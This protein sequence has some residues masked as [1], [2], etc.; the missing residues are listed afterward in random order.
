[1]NR[2]ARRSTTTCGGDGSSTSIASSLVSTS[3]AV[4][5]SSSPESTRRSAPSLSTVSKPMG[6]RRKAYAPSRGAGGTLRQGQAQFG[7]GFLPSLLYSLRAR[8]S[9]S[10][11]EAFT[12]APVLPTLRVWKESWLDDCVALELASAVAGA[13]LS[14][15]SA[16]SSATR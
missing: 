12:G 15:R 4:E 3:A 11:S 5:K 13:R 2:S 6:K 14:A 7:H 8:R 10:S 1:M 9:C 16:A